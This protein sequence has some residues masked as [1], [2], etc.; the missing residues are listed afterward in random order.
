MARDGLTRRDFLWAGA[1]GAA[2]LAFGGQLMAQEAAQPADLDYSYGMPRRVLGKTGM[3]ASIL[4]YG[5]HISEEVMKVPGKRESQIRY[6]LENG[7]NFY[8][9]PGNQYEVMSGLLHGHKDVLISMPMPDGEDPMGDLERILKIFRRDHIDLIRMWTGG[10]QY[11]GPKRDRIYEAMALAA[12]QGKVR[13]VGVSGHKEDYLLFEMKQRDNAFDFALVVYNFHEHNDGYR[14]FAPLARKHGMAL[15]GMKAFGMGSLLKLT[16][17]L[18]ADKNF[19]DDP[20]VDV[21]LAALRY[22]YAN[23]DIAITIPA[24][25]ELSE[26]KHN[27]KVFPHRALSPREA[28]F[29]KRISAAA[30]ERCKSE[31]WKL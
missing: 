7:I 14:E 13:A 18:R 15:I 26:I 24:M 11:A 19:E 29:L 5:S 20:E 16:G 8:A 28:A 1:L 6:A 31:E 27:L 9:T 4:G 3:A 23:P 22:V 25:Y 17:Q 10:K 12:R 30:G 21:A 2:S